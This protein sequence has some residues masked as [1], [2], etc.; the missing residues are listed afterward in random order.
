[1]AANG[2]GTASVGEARAIQ[3]ILKGRPWPP[4][5]KGFELEFGEDSTGDPAVWV[6]LMI[7]D[8]VS[9]PAEKIKELGRFRRGLVSAIMDAGLSH[10]PYVRFRTRQSEER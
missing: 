6:W 7:D 5:V 9:P 3:D 2:E 8:D 10:W 4:A 1:M